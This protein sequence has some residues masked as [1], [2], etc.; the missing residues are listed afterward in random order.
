M[1]GRPVEALD[2]DLDPVLVV[3]AALELLVVELRK[4]GGDH[5][6]EPALVRGDRLEAGQLGEPKTPR[7][8]EDVAT[9]AHVVPA[10]LGE[11]VDRGRDGEE[12]RRDRAYP[13]SGSAPRSPRL[14]SSPS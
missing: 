3:E 1:I 12:R 9:A 8:G 4:L 11:E 14:A 13:A 6:P 5:L 10:V 2:G 7:L